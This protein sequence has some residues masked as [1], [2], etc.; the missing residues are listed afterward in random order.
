M[1]LYF[2]RQGRL[3]QT[4]VAA[5]FLLVLA[6]AYTTEWI[7]IHALFG[8]FLMGAIMPK[9]TRFV[10]TL[11]E[12]LED[13]TVVLLLP[14]FFAYTGLRTQIGLL[15]SADLWLDTLLI[16]AVACL[17]KFGGSTLAGVAC[18]LSVRESSVIGILMNTRGLMEL[19]ILNIGLQEGVITPAVFAMMVIMALVTTALTTPVLHWIYPPRLFEAEK[20]P[21]SRSHASRS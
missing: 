12:K 13:Y 8:A 17:G 14:I 5:I 20:V 19:V 3:S 11:S 7:G 6:S 21:P 1:Q 18:G 4:I 15:N 9:G 2:D 10:R 16:T